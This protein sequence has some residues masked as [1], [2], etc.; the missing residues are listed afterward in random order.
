[1]TWLYG[2]TAT[3]VDDPVLKVRVNLAYVTHEAKQKIACV[4]QR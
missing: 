2:C 4:E 3:T 1:M